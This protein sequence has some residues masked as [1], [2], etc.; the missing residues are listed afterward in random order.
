MVTVSH[1][2]IAT[3]N[4]VRGSCALPVFV[5]IAPGGF[6]IDTQPLEAAIGPKTQVLLAELQIVMPCDLAALAAIAQAYGVPLL[7]D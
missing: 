1:S 2:F 6:N 7:E 5:D 4:V 3:A